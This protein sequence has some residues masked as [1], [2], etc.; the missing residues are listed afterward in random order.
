VHGELPTTTPAASAGDNP[1]SFHVEPEE[2]FRTVV[3][4]RWRN[5]CPSCFDEE[6]QKAGVRY[7]FIDLD[8]TSW[9]D[10]QTPRRGGRKR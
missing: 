5:I 1:I 3:L 8:G 9:S 7:R 2:A 10:R 4:N 6:A